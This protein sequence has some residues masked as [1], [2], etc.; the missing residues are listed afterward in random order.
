L[1][2]NEAIEYTQSA[3]K[4]FDPTALT[5]GFARRVAGYKRWSLLLK[6]TER[7]LSIIN[8]ENK[9]VQLV[10]AGKAHPQDQGAKQ[11]LQQVAL[12]KYDARVRNRAVVL[13]NYDQEIARQLVQSVDVWLNVPRRPFEASGTSGEKV[14]MNGGLNLSVLDG[15]WL[16]G[17]DGA[18]GF[19]VGA[20]VDAVETGDDADVDASDA[21]SLYRTLEQEVVPLYYDR[22]EQGLPRKWIAMMKRSIETL[23]PK[24]NSDRMVREYAERIY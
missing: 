19:A 12:W 20:G 11:I 1:D 18:N 22:D 24:F 15:W 10:F 8:N 14:A 4:M 21:E 7:L 9:P 16:E 17:Y 2:R 23:V 6:D 13:Q 5:I 3:Q